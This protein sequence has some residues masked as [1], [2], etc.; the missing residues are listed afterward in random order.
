MFFF[1]TFSTGKT[2]EVS[3]SSEH[4]V[5][6]SENY[7]EENEVEP[8]LKHGNRVTLDRWFLITG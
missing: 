7:S 6:D 8:L 2:I 3:V 4:S 1:C 5:N